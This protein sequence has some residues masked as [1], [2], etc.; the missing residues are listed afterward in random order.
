[1]QLLP[2]SE[3]L[4]FS[5]NFQINDIRIKPDKQ[6][7]ETRSRVRLRL[8]DA[9]EMDNQSWSNLSLVVV[10]EFATSQDDPS[11]NILSWLL[12]D[13]ELKGHIESPQE[14]FVDDPQM[15]SA[16]KLDLLMIT[17]G[18]SRYIWSKPEEYLALKTADEEGFN[19]SGTVNRVVGNIP[20]TEGTVELKVYN[21]DFMHMDELEI[22]EE[23]RF[24]FEDVNFMDTAYVFIQAR[25]KRDKLTFKV[26]LDPL[27]NKFPESSAKYLPKLE[28][29][30][31][32][33][34]ELY[35]KQY[36]NLQAL[37]EYTLSSGAFYIEEVTVYDYKR[38]KDDGHFRIYP[39]PTNSKEITNRDLT[40]PS[41]IDYIQGRFAGVT[42]T[43]TKNI[44]IRGK[45]S[46]TGGAL[47]AEIFSMRGAEDPGHEEEYTS[48]LLLLDGLPV[49][50]DAFLS[51]P[52]SDIDK[53]EVLK[54]PGETAIFGNRG[55]GGVVSVF[56]KRGGAP[57]YIDKYL[58]GTIAEKLAGYASNREFYSPKY[59][60][61]TINAERP[62]H[63]I[64][65]HWDPNIFTEK[66]RASV[67]FYASDDLSRYN[68]YVEGI[69]RDGKI[70]LGRAKFEVDKRQETQ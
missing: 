9:R 17:Q 29:T 51:I 16:T 48:A 70:C 3:R 21:S 47:R 37:K 15:A 54:N 4:I 60:P 14:Y 44:I 1:E 61:E 23:G 5:T 38:E 39:K 50:K 10:D 45:S 26:S 18:W 6:A 12:I 42:V 67:S 53:V 11:T 66:G 2:V 62:D 30:S 40:Y 20:V 19:I 13:S 56:T 46:L 68:V 28:S 64:V 65:L 27:F 57:E 59:T 24:I 7:Y 43:S 22:N 25:N 34:A 52:M 58:P 35:Q 55:A 49:S 32:K 36:D 33:Q 41:V 69:T 63:R 31:V 8:S